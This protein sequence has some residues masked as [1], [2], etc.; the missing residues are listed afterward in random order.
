[1]RAKYDY[2]CYEYGGFHSYSMPR[3]ACVLAE[4]L[5]T[6]QLIRGRLLTAAESRTDEMTG[7]PMS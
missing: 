4:E 6:L 2:K 7:L 5:Q 3:R 1:M